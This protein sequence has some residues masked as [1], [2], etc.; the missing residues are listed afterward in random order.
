MVE[1]VAVFVDCQADVV[2]ELWYNV[3]AFGYFFFEIVE[4][5]DVGV[6]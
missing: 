2:V 1:L 4:V 5:V 6:I 3:V